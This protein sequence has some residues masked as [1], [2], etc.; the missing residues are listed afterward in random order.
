GIVG[1]IAV[2]KAT[3]ALFEAYLND[4]ERTAMQYR[5]D[6]YVTGDRASKDEEGYF[7]FEGRGDVIIISSGFTIGPF[8]V[9]TSVLEHR[10]VKKCVVVERLDQVCLNY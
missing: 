1:D 8:E 5:G 3:P 10:A 9:E 6:Y 4:P 7:W 2:H